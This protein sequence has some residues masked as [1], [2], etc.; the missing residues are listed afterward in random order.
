MTAAVAGFGFVFIHPFEDGNGRL[1]RFL[2]QKALVD[3]GFNPP[4]VILP[5]SAA[6]LEDLL[7]YR[8]ALED[9]S[10]PTLRSIEWTAAKLGNVTVTNETDYLY[11]Y[12]D[13]TRQAEYLVDRIERTV[14]VS[15]PAELDFLHK[16]DLLKQ[17]ISAE[18]DLPD[19]IMSLF[20]QFCAQNGGKLSNAKRN[21]YFAL[22]D[23]KTV[24]HL[25]HLVQR[26]GIVELG[27]HGQGG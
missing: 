19:R 10:L 3:T 17:D 14:H 27:S 23:D 4:G 15:L 5:V 26:S 8:A 22:L 2:I 25:E 7:G 12:F 9:Y 24:E 6:I 11:R 21:Q 20:I 1:H 13:A 18:L 16:F